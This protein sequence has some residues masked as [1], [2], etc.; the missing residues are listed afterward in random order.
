MSPEQTLSILKP[1]AVRMN[2]VG[3]ILD[4]F[5]TAGLRVIACRM[6]RLT[7][8]QA[9]DFYSV[10]SERPFFAELVEYM[11]S[12]PVVVQILEGDN[13]IRRN[14]EVMGAT[15]PVEATL[16]TIRADFAESVQA[17][18]VHGS[19]TDDNAKKEI[20]FFFSECERI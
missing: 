6:L 13:A 5:E 11:I 19:D 18:A 4:R 3:K 15:N 16:G 7:R 1:D 17:N 9:E 14:R 20:N 8:E 12:G 10:H 2:A